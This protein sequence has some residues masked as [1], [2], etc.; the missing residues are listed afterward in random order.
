MPQSQLIDA[1]KLARTFRRLGET[2]E[3]RR[4][5]RRA[6]DRYQDFVNLWEHADASLQPAVKDVR[7]R[8]ERIRPKAG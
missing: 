1:Y 2:Y 5:W 4:D 8:I 7:A 6:M 3:Q